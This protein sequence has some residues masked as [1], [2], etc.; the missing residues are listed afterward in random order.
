MGWPN[1]HDYSDYGAFEPIHMDDAYESSWDDQY[2]ESEKDSMAWNDWMSMHTA[3]E[4]KPDHTTMDWYGTGNWA[5]KSEPIH[6]PT[7]MNWDNGFNPG[8]FLSKG[9]QGSNGKPKGSMKKPKKG[10][11]AK[12]KGKEGMK[13]KIKQ[14]SKSIKKGQGKNQKKKPKAGKA[15]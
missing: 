5:E 12:N 13:E 14:K 7:S 9:I 8:D 11:T 15:G 1:K 10:Q 4:S 2:Y 3:S 6:T